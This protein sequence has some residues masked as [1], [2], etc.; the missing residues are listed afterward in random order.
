[1]YHRHSALVGIFEQLLQL[2]VGASLQGVALNIKGDDQ[3]LCFL[4]LEGGP[5]SSLDLM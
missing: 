1:M 5:E 2:V 3:Q 4:F